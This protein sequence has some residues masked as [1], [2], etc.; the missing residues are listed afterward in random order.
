MT[1]KS[2]KQP[3]QSGYLVDISRGI[4]RLEIA[5]SRLSTDNQ[6]SSERQLELYVSLWG[7]WTEAQRKAVKLMALLGFFVR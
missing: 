5:Q 7:R 4:E 3:F 2:I 1:A 6:K